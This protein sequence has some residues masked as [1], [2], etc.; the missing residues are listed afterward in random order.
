MF[1]PV[2]SVS[3]FVAEHFEVLFEV[4]EESLA[5]VDKISS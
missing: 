5:R 3:V 4:G 2:R 1:G